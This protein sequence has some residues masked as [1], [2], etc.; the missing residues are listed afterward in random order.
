MAEDQP[1]K[2]IGCLLFPGF[3]ALDL[4]GPLDALNIISRTQPL[5]ICLL[6]RTLDPVSNIAPP[7]VPL[8]ATAS[9]TFGQSVVPTH[10]LASHPPLDVLLVPGGLGT[11]SPDL[12]PELD[13]LR[14]V[15]PSLRYLITVCTGSGLAARAGV[16]DGRQATTNKAA[17]ATVAAWGRS[18]RWIAQARWVVDGNVW[19]SSGISAGLDVTFAWI[20][21]VWGEDVAGEAAVRMEYERHLDASWDPFAAL[22]GLVDQEV[23]K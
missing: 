7:S 19:T 13:F 18:T 10:T 17:F 5:S 1:P 8:P 12:E 14:T 9:P 21:H 15:Y 3:Q 20:K 4:F 2:S 6:S 23:E 11:R 22:Y 16:L